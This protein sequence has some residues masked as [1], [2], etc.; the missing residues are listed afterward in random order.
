MG[1]PIVVDL[2]SKDIK[3]GFAYG[4]PSEEEPRLVS[5]R[6]AAAPAAP[7]EQVT[8]TAATVSPD[9]RGA[10]ASDLSSSAP[11]TVHPVQ[12]GVV[13]NWDALEALLHYSLYEQLGW[14]E[15][16][17]AGL[18]VVEPILTSR[19]E[20]ERLAQLAF[21]V[22]NVTGYLATDA[23]VASLY[24]AGRTSGLVVDLGHDKIDVAPV[25][26]GAVQASAARRLPYGGRQLTA[27]L[28]GLLARRPG[29]GPPPPPAA[30]EL[31]KLACLRVAPSAE[32]AQAEMEA[33]AAAPATHTLPDGQTFSVGGEGVAAGEALLAPALLGL[34]LPPLAEA[35]YAAGQAPWVQGE[36]EARK[37][38]AEG[39]LVCGGGAG[40]AG[41]GERLLAE[42]RRLA[43]PAAPP[44]LCPLPDYLPAHTAQ[45]AAWMGGAVLAKVAFG[46]GSGPAAQLQQPLSK[47][48]YDEMGPAAIHRKCG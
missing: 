4:W 46:G 48:D 13:T 3:A 11:L 8:P 28:G 22:F 21:E 39:V 29:G 44:G 32:A 18:L 45:R 27:H 37:V 19:D 26:E 14:A 15:G 23:A 5:T 38:V 33:A 34:D 25:V 41:L 17:E 47:A 7:L 1:E 24:A 42:L 36:R 9:A 2:G 40:A 6:A 43:H 35:V 16:G 10:N 31:L 12:R 20:R 30:A